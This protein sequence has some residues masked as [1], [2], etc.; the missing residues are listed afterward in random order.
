[1]HAV[2]DENGDVFVLLEHCECGIL[3][4]LILSHTFKSVSEVKRLFRQIIDAVSY[5]HGRGI[6]RGDIQPDNIVLRAD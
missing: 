1:L 4:D 2:V 6:G 5:F 3:L